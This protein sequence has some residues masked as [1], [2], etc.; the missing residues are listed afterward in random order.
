MLWFTLG[1]CPSSQTPWRPWTL[2]P[3]EA[4]PTRTG[5][6]VRSVCGP[7]RYQPVRPESSTISTMKGPGEASS[8]SPSLGHLTQNCLGVWEWAPGQSGVDGVWLR[9]GLAL[10]CF[11][12]LKSNAMMAELFQGRRKRFL[13]H[14]VFLPPD[15]TAGSGERRPWSPS[16]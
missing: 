7:C 16:N 1:P 14:C 6:E 3:Q 15:N 5:S 2:T 11:C 8:A 4:E 9:H 13:P 12:F 10:A